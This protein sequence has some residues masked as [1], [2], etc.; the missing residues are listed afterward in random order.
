MASLDKI[1]LFTKN[2]LKKLWN[3]YLNKKITLTLK[4]RVERIL[5]KLEIGL[6]KSIKNKRIKHGLYVWLSQMICKN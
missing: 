3:N 1:M 4:K 2:Q 5:I 6:I